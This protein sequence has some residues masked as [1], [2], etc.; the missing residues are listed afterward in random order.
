MFVAIWIDL[1]AIRYGKVVK[2]P[3]VYNLLAGV[4]NTAATIPL[5]TSLTQ[6]RVARFK[7]KLT[8]EPATMIKM[9]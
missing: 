6:N 3:V 9:R 7:K 8:P 2:C 5:P 1:S 4:S